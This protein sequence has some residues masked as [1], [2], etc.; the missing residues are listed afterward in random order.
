MSQP[1]LFWHDYETFGVDPQ[2]DR[3]CQFAGIRT[4][5]DF[6]IIGDPVMAYCQPASDCLPHPEACLTT[7]ITPQIAQERGVCEAEF[8]RL[9][10]QEMATPQT[11]SLGYNS[12]RFDDEVSRNLF[13]RNF[14]DPYVREWQMGN[15]RW[16]L[17]DVI[18]AAYALR[19]DGI[20]W[21]IDDDGNPSFRLELL[22]KANDLG[23]DSAHDALSDVY[24]TIAIARLIREKQP[25]L[26]QFLFDNRH[27]QAVN[28]LFQ[29]GSYTPLVHISG[30]YPTSKHCLAIVIP[31][32]QHPTNS[33]ELIVYDL[34]I[35]P[36]ALLTLDAESIR[37]R[38]FIASK[39]LPEGV[40]RI[41]LKTIHI[42]RCPVLA[43]LKVVRDVDYN[44]LQLDMPSC[45]RHLSM[46]KSA[47]ELKEK[48]A[49]VF[50][51]NYGDSINDPDLMI[52]SGGFF[53]P[54]DKT[55][56]TRIR[57]SKPEALAELTFSFEDERLP[58]MLFRYR[59]RNY[60]DTL[61]SDEQ[62]KWKKY[63]HAVFTDES[64]G[65]VLTLTSM[66][67]KIHSLKQSLGDD[68][69]ILRQLET[70][71]LDKA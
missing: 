62:A 15:S 68:N 37:Q 24:A 22:T 12:L 40:D 46:I 5:Y 3:P 17:I 20:V 28:K 52:Y 34:S 70:Y 16:D 57:E 71:L 4:D 48:L 39:D 43:P 27:K 19:P 29:L 36:E 8:A 51:R 42:N 53:S 6:N 55:E 50:R 11:C 66:H 13:Y 33:N 64:I 1:S 49:E 67:Q 56:M 10:H 59:A 63:C 47:P 30:R 7:G 25:R 41:A 14:Y 2:R 31:I 54:K 26:Y 69:E 35:N 18:R 9:I 65:P 32:C 44:R 38:L 60:C 23:H 45:M 61:N 58:E 21:P